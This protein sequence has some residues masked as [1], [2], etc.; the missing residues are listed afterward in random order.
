MRIKPSMCEQL[1]KPGRWRQS[2]SISKCGKFDGLYTEVY[3]IY[4]D[5]KYTCPKKK[6]LWFAISC[7]SGQVKEYSR[8]QAIYYP[9]SDSPKQFLSCNFKGETRK[10]SL[11]HISWRCVGMC[12][13]EKFLFTFQIRGVFFPHF[14]LAIGGVLPPGPPPLSS[15]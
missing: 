11:G 2:F 14:V 3:G 1:T 9:F 7:K 6:Q 5:R 12:Y 4:M 13:F 10:F 15:H 8:K